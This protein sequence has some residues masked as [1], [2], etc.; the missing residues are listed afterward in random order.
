MKILRMQKPA[1][2]LGLLLCTLGVIALVAT[3]WETWPQVS[4]AKDPFSTFLGLL[5]TEK[6]N[7][8]SDFEFRLVY[9]VIF[10]DAALIA[11]VTVCALSVRWFYLPGKIVWY[12]CPFCNKDWKSSGDKALVHCPHC[13]Q[14]V[15]PVMIE[16][17]PE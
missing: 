17:K 2:A 7:F 9:L 3:L 10:A 4:T 1:Y 12:R 15:H 11:G 5:W 14:L 16:K 6:L 8:I 13:R